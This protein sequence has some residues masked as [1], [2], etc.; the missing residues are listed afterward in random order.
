MVNSE[1]VMGFLLIR[2]IFSFSR[3]RLSL[4]GEQDV[5]LC[6]LYAAAGCERYTAESFGFTSLEVRGKSEE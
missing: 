1:K 4:G 5:L 2:F 3:F 6:L